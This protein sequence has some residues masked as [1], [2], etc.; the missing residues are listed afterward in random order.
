MKAFLLRI[1]SG[2]ELQRSGM[3]SFGLTKL[4]LSMHHDVRIECLDTGKNNVP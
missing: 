2:L 4:R 1:S 3:K